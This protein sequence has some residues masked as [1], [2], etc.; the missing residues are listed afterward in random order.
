MRSRGFR[1][2]GEMPDLTAEAEMAQ[3]LFPG[4]A[5]EL[6]AVRT[7]ALPRGTARELC[8]CGHSCSCQSPGPPGTALAPGVTSRAISQALVTLPAGRDIPREPGGDKTPESR[9][10]ETPGDSNLSIGRVKAIIF[11]LQ[12]M[13]ESLSGLGGSNTK[14]EGGNG[15]RSSKTPAPSRERCLWLAGGGLCPHPTAP[16]HGGQVHR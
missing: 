13:A 1:G 11:Y 9:G 10:G 5:A 4:S 3:G 12:R 8:W 15:L 14:G 2:V 16:T 6:A 7:A